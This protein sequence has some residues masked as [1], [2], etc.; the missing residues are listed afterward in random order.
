LTCP[1]CG[2][3]NPPEAT[4]CDDCGAVLAAA[5]ATPEAAGRRDPLPVGA[6]IGP[7]AVDRADARGGFN[8]YRASAGERVVRVV[9]DAEAPPSPAE[10]S[11]PA[12]GDASRTA[13]V[14]KAL[15]LSEC[16]HLW[17]VRE[18]LYQDE[19]AFIVGDPLPEL[20]LQ[21]HLAQTESLD[22]EEIRA[23]GMSLLEGLQ[24]L[25]ER[26][27]LHLGVHPSQVRVDDEGLAILD[28]YERIV[29]R[30]ALP[31]R[32]SVLDGYSAPEAYGIG[33]T[34]CP[35]SDVFG[36]GATLYYAISRRVPTEVSREQFFYFPPLAAQAPDVPEDLERIVMK[37]V[38]K[39][40]QARYPTA[41]AMSVDLLQ[42]SMEK[43]AQKVPVAVGGGSG[44]TPPPS[45]E[46]P[47]S[48]L[49]AVAQVSA[50][51]PAALPPQGGFMPYRVGMRSDVGRVRSVNQDS[52][53]V[54]TFH[55]C[56]RSVPSEALLIIVADG[57]GG[58]A[59]GDKAS[60]LAIRSM[61]AHVL[62]NHMPIITGADTMKLRSKDPAERLEELLR[63]AMATANRT[64][65]QYSQKDASRRGMGSTLTSLMIDW[66]HAVFGHAGDTRAY[67]VRGNL[68]QVT[69]DHSLVGKLVRLGQ[70]TREEA[71][72]SPQR[73]YLYRAM[74][75][76]E[77][78]EVD[79][80]A[81]RLEPGDRLLICSD[82]VWEYYTDEEVIDLMTRFDDPQKAC[83]A[84]IEETLRRGADDNCTAVVLYVPAT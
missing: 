79:V 5:A 83:D 24:A 58:E 46:R 3:D 8:V 82:G 28:G 55:A 64:I 17:A 77:D 32:F 73:S 40:L 41:E 44:P 49:A 63:E 9:E 12:E 21:E 29:R 6:R 15:E 56:E 69:E 16:P 31:Q 54:M 18:Y 36:V 33:G 65:Y 60:S 10:G 7:F 68:D 80:Y 45:W 42:A 39:T 75:T 20:T 4:Y 2:L 72:H 35:A 48:P 50:A 19:R 30:D 76:A 14:W 38:A 51:H 22:A 34:P 43:R 78:L 52:M 84:F 13:L 47:M 37:A 61:A 57:M 23:L 1:S 26:G 81:R 59:E 67:L 53:L 27:F 70:L 25:H 62:N 71:R 66:P 11:G 74:G